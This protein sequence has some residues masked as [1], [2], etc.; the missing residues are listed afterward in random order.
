MS[1]IHLS[2]LDFSENKKGKITALWIFALKNNL[3]IK[4]LRECQAG[5]T[6]SVSKSI[7]ACTEIFQS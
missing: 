5:K 1:F 6:Y 2:I 3:K 7:E 4:S